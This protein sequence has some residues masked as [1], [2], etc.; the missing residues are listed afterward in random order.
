MYLKTLFIYKNSD[1]D[2][3]LIVGERIEGDKLNGYGKDI[4]V[5]GDDSVI[6]VGKFKEGELD[7]IGAKI[8]NGVA[9]ESGLYR[10]GTLVSIEEFKNGAKMKIIKESEK[11]GHKYR[12]CELYYH[13]GDKDHI[14]GYALLVCE[15]T[16]VHFISGNQIVKGDRSCLAFGEYKD[17]KEIGLKAFINYSKD[18]GVTYDYFYDR[19]DRAFAVFVNK[20]HEARLFD[21]EKVEVA[22]GVETLEKGFLKP[23]K[24]TILYLPHSVKKICDSA[25]FSKE[26]YYLEV[27]YDGSLEDWEKIE[28][29]REEWGTR[30]DF[31]GYYY[32]NSERYVPEKNYYN[33]ARNTEFIAIHCN[34]GELLT[35]DNSY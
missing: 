17:N 15:K 25:V 5:E 34:D 4:R 2:Y 19:Y 6:F 9:V 10:N 24:S 33:W 21:W 35:Y 30:E 22:E 20:D 12:D 27:F 23:S 31:Y 16:I 14:S 1:K 8:K 32:H 29:G 13:E 7:G 11:Y 18:K 26:N 28:K 3:H